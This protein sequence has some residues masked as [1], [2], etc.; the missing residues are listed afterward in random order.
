MEKTAKNTTSITITLNDRIFTGLV[1]RDSGIPKRLLF[2]V[3]EKDGASYPVARL[4]LRKNGAFV[5][6]VSPKH[7]GYEEGQALL[8]KLYRFAETHMEI[9]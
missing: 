5:F 9:L 4:R 2:L 1:R 6:H 8:Y 3:W 7:F